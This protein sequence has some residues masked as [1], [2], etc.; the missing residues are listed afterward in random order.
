MEF[1][2]VYNVGMKS[3]GGY[4][5]TYE[6][7]TDAYDIRGRHIGVVRVGRDNDG[8]LCIEGGKYTGA[9]KIDG[10]LF[11]LRNLGKT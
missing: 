7:V 6:F 2:D 8:K 1:E 5:L 10:S 4:P 9:E 3:Y 11:Y